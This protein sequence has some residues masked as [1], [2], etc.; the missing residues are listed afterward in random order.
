MSET[1]LALDVG[2]RR[3]GVAVGEGTFAF[4][5]ATLERTNVRDDVAA[6]VAIARERGA[7]TIVVGDPLT[8]SGERAL[9]SEKIDQ[10]VA[11]LARAFDGTIERVD[12]RLTTAAA[13]K[14]LIGADVS[15]AKRKKVVDQLAAVGILETWLA[16]RP[17]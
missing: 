16:R 2:T 15:R 14:V 7:R 12:E 8:M 11:H 9:A 10:F 3:I 17:R 5:H 1:V 6:I 13:Q 4:P